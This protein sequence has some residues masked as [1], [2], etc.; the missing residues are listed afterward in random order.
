M[1]VV[2][3]EFNQQLNLSDRADQT[4]LFLTE[5]EVCRRDLST[6]SSLSAFTLL[7]VNDGILR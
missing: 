6:D 3:L 1:P 5:L 4:T 7:V 2:I